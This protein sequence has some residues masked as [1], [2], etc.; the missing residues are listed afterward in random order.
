MTSDSNSNK[1]DHPLVS[2]LINILIPVVILNKGANL[3]GGHGHLYALLLALS[4]PFI[5]GLREYV[6]FHSKN[7]VSILGVVNAILTG[8]LALGRLDGLWFAFKDASLPICL[9]G[10][11]LISS[12]TEN[13][14]TRSIF[15][16]PKVIK[17]DVLQSALKEKGKTPD[18]DEL[19]RKGT[20][21][22]SISFFLSGIMNFALALRVFTHIDPHLSDAEHGQVLNQ[23]IAHMTW[24]SLAIVAL[25]LLCFT[26]L[27]LFWFFRRLHG[28]TGLT[29]E[30]LTVD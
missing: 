4:F 7:Y 11:V 19:L 5:Y 30:Q 9:G 20:R 13:P 14:F 1:N 17:V 8:G 21:L 12:Y 25:P 26:G 16:N 10:Y 27:F 18:F 3:L 24:L 28:L 22:F 6:L 15:L 23:Q 29:M 2:L